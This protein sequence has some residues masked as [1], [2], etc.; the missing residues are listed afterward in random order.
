MLLNF[1]FKIVNA[2]AQ[3]YLKK[4]QEKELAALT[5]RASAST[6]SD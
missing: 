5:N 6:H 2:T 3:M 4:Q 1:F